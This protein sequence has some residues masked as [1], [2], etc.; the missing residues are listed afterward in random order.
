MM[1]TTRKYHRLLGFPNSV[2]PKLLTG[3]VHV[4]YTEHAQEAAHD[5]GLCLQQLPA[6]LQIQRHQIIEI[7]LDGDDQPIKQLV[8][9][10]FRCGADLCIALALDGGVRAKTLWLQDTCDT[11]ETLN[12]SQ[13]S[14]PARSHLAERR[15]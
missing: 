11:H 8:R 5:N 1:N 14:I 6:T 15:L 3:T 4:E 2:L 7:A 13:Y 9:I 10:P 12:R